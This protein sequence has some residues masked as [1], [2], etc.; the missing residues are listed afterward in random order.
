M[1]EQTQLVVFD[2]EGTLTTDPTVWEL[3]H[4]KVG[5]W[6]SHGL[7]YWE[8]FK[9]SRVGYDEFARMDVATWRNAPC[10][11][12]D[13][14]VREAP[15]MQ[16][17]ADMLGF[18]NERGIR[19]AIVSNGLE[20]LARRLAGEFAVARVEA[21]RAATADGHL[22]GD[23]DIRVPFD[24]KGETLRQIARDMNV[25]LAQI[26]AVGDGPADVAM[27]RLAGRSVAF[28]PDSRRIAASADHVILKPDLTRLIPLFE[29]HGS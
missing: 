16:G 1:P 3:M 25:P 8:E 21:N 20:C 29:E 9:A 4:L 12:L 23:V 28:G 27:F 11:L 7:P 10:A 13:Q 5:T 6:E 2:M 14:A 19:T 15:L 26:M 18:L 17:C 24:R 22:T